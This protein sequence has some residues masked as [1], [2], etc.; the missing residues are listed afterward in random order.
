MGYLNDAENNQEKFD[1]H[2]WLRTGDLGFLDTDK[3]LYVVGNTRDIITL[4]SG[5]RIN[6]NPIEERVKRYIPL[7]RYVVL[8]GQDAPY[9]C[10]LLTLKCQI[11]TDTGEPRN[12]LTSEAVAFCRQL[13][14]QATRLSD[15]VY[16]GDP[17]VLEFIGQGIDAANAEVTSD[18]AKIMKWTILR[19]DFSVAGGELGA[20]TKLKRAMVARIYQAEIENLYEEDDY[21]D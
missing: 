4:S 15:I 3:F 9:L 14:S 8:V 13:R 7:V 21:D 17:V 2:G 1:A 16:D 12:A 19:T 10:A 20:T 5:E 18:S 11:N 6:P